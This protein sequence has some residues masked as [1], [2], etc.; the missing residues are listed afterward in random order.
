M[1]VGNKLGLEII[2]VV[3][4]GRSGSTY[5]EQCLTSAFRLISLSEVFHRDVSMPFLPD[6]VAWQELFGNGIE[7]FLL[8]NVLRGMEQHYWTAQS[9]GLN[10]GVSSHLLLE[11]KPT[12]VGHA[13]HAIHSQVFLKLKELGVG[14]VIV[15]ERRSV[16]RRILSGMSAERTQIYHSTQI[17][18]GM[19]YRFERIDFD[20]N[21]VVDSGINPGY[22]FALSHVQNINDLYFAKL[23]LELQATGFEVLDVIY[24]DDVC[25]P[26]DTL[27]DRIGLFIGAQA[28][29][30]P[31]TDLRKLNPNDLDQMV[32]N[33]AELLAYCIEN[34]IRI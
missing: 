6:G 7:C 26:I 28:V 17:E 31:S 2:P 11:Y 33:H 23:R 9:Q 22:A 29:Q 13:F 15:L 16:L 20:F 19:D 18:S 12:L 5:L 21:K 3:H 14:K 27:I 10:P 25:G 4:L 1:T 8:H 24:E 34:N 32:I 30:K